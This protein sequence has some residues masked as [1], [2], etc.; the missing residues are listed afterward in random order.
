[1]LSCLLHQGRQ[2]ACNTDRISTCVIRSVLAG[3]PSYDAWL[4]KDGLLGGRFKADKILKEGKFS[5]GTESA[6]EH[7][8]ITLAR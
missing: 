1:M 3:M 7:P 6:V 2:D 8:V 5:T 4:R